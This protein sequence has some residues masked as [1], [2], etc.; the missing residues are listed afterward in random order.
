MTRVRE[1]AVLMQEAPF[2]PR[3]SMLQMR[4]HLQLLSSGTKL[5]GYEWA[6]LQ[7]KVCWAEGAGVK[8]VREPAVLI[9][10]APFWKHHQ[11]VGSLDLVCLASTHR[12]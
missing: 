3:V 7:A 4:R 12:V 2:C 1:P 9:Q 11:H 5:T 8:S 10:E 6:G